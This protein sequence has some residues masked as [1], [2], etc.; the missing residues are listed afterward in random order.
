MNIP[1]QR[2]H[3]PDD[4]GGILGNWSG[5]SQHAGTCHIEHEQPIADSLPGSNQCHNR[6][7]SFDGG[8]LKVDP[9]DT[10]VDENGIPKPPEIPWPRFHPVPTRPVFG[11]SAL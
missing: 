10:S 6:S 8:A 5:C 9:F 1:S 2:A 11:T 4:R 3:D 7:N